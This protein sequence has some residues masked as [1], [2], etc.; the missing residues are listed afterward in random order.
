MAGEVDRSLTVQARAITHARG[1]DSYDLIF[2]VL[3]EAYERQYGV[4]PDQHDEQQLRNITIGFVGQFVHLTDHKAVKFYRGAE[5]P[6][7]PRG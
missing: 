5:A 6:P 7:P 2:D 4:G 1:P 3:T